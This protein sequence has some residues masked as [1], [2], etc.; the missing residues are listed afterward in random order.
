IEDEPSINRQNFFSSHERI[1]TAIDNDV[2][3]VQV[4]HYI[5]SAVARYEERQK[6]KK[7]KINE[8]TIDKIQLMAFKE[9]AN[10][11]PE[12]YDYYIKLRE[13]D[14]DEI[15]IE[16]L[17]EVNT[18]FA[19]II[20]NAK[21]MINSFLMSN[22]PQDEELNVHEEARQRL[23]FF[24][25]IIEDCD[26]YKNFY[27]GGKCI[28]LENDLQRMFKLVWYGT[29]YKAD[30]ETNNGRGPADAIVSKGQNNQCVVEFKLAS[31]SR[32]PHVF[33]QVQ[34]Y[35]AANNAEGSLVAIFYFTQK[36][37]EKALRVVKDAGYEEK[38]D[39]SIFLIDCRKDNK[40]SASKA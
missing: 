26:A 23:K 17:Y 1:R 16:C 13:A 2:L 25:H 34:I 28:A 20:V 35:E 18:Q 29:S 40:P 30:F 8:K 21:K 22:H 6:E 31:N 11:Y 14:T 15:R 39:E 9:L 36:D 32:L 24:K 12:L 33:E 5:A 38:I 3:R 19:K 10:E 7:G 37:Y 27:V 4:E